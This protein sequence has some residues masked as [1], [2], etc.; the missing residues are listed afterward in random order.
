[1]KKRLLT[2]TKNGFSSFWAGKKN[3]LLLKNTGDELKKAYV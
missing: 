1:M 2:G 3:H